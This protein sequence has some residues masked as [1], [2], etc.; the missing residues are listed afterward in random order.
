MCLR[1]NK[2]PIFTTFLYCP[3]RLKIALGILTLS[4]ILQSRPTGKVIGGAPIPIYV[5][6]VD[7]GEKK[8]LEQRAGLRW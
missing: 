4:I 5:G 1:Q 7:G 3:G 2:L 6:V 8:N